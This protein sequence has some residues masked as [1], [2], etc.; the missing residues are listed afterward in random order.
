VPGVLFSVPSTWSHLPTPTTGTVKTP[1]LVPQFTAFAGYAGTLNVASGDVNDN[2]VADLI[3]ATGAGTEGRVSA[4]GVNG[5]T[6]SPIGNTLIPFG[7][8]FTGGVSVAAGDVTGDGFSE[9]IVGTQTKGDQVKIYML[10]G[11]IYNQIDNTITNFGTLPA[12]A[13]L[14][15]SAI[16]VGGLGVYDIAIGV[17]SSGVGRVE[18]V[19][20]ND[21]V[22]S[23]VYVG[24]GLTAMAISAYNSAGSGADSLLIGTIPAG[25][26][27]FHVINPSTGQQTSSFSEL[28]AL[29]GGIALAGI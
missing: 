28:P 3:V 10:E 7:T 18:V 5:S 26:V 24:A 6:I 1:V 22:L 4:Y 27:Q 20:Q 9:I 12:T 15:V 21:N 8:T 17:L 13:Q 11:S 19:D 29:T 14:Q 16:D 2:G 23:N 25:P